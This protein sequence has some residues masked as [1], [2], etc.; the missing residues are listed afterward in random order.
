MLD[1]KIPPPKQK[2]GLHKNQIALGQVYVLDSFLKVFVLISLSD[3]QSDPMW[4]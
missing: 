3:T 2:I 4:V 1:S